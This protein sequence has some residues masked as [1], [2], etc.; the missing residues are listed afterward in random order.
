MLRSLSRFLVVIL[1]LSGVVMGHVFTRSL[2]VLL[3]IVVRTIMVLWVSPTGL[4]LVIRPALKLQR[5][6]G[7]TPFVWCTIRVPVP[8]LIPRR[9]LW[10]I[11]FLIF[12]DI[13]GTHTWFAVLAIPIGP[14]PRTPA[15]VLLVFELVRL[16]ILMRRI[17][18]WV[19]WIIVLGLTMIVLAPF[20]S[21][22]V[23]AVILGIFG[24]QL[25]LVGVIFGF[26][27][28]RPSISNKKRV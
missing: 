25:A 14:G 9:P 12:I 20:I 27:F 6:L 24:I 16:T 7:I 23:P 17:I 28:V 22:E 18:V 13:L 8:L 2:S 26:H 10:G 15:V 5:T 19:F 11:K 3:I 4:F 1:R 21:I